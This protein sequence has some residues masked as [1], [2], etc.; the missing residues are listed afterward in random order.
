MNHNDMDRYF[1]RTGRRWSGDGR[2]TESFD[3]S[4][5]DG[6]TIFWVGI[7]LMVTLAALILLR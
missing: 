2:P 1:W 7:S 4:K 6:R 5:I 3:R